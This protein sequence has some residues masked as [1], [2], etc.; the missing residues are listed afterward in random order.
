MS[1]STLEQVEHAVIE[2][3]EDGSMRFAHVVYPKSKLTD[4]MVFG[5]PVE[6]LC[7]HT[8]VPGRDPKRYPL[9]PACKEIYESLNK[10]ELPDA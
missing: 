2:R 10:G 6:A 5:T 9:C 3:T 8:W 7:G 4:A 1:T